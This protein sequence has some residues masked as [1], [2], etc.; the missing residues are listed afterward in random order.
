MSAKGM[1]MQEF[2]PGQ[3]VYDVETAKGSTEHNEKISMY[4]FQASALTIVM[5]NSGVV[6]VMEVTWWIKNPGFKPFNAAQRTNWQKCVKPTNQI[7]WT[8]EM[9]AG[10]SKYWLDFRNLSRTFEKMKNGNWSLGSKTLASS[11]S[12]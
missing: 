7:G 8:F 6:H 2:K 11:I 10:R 1:H 9:L 5:N 4:T 3:I 12:C